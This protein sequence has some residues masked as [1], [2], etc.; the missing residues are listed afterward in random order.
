ML[1]P[2]VIPCLLIKDNYLVKTVNFSNEK[3]IGDPLNAVKIFNEKQVDE[4]MIID[5]SA[6]SSK[7][8]PNFD[9]IAK[10]ANESRMPL[11]YG[12]GVKSLG[13]AKKIIGLGVEKICVSSA[14]VDRRSLCHEISSS[15][16]AQGLVAFIDAKKNFLGKYQ[17]VTNR[18]QTK[19]NIELLGLIEIFQKNGIGELVINC[20][21]KDG[22][23]NGYDIGFIKKIDSK[24]KVPLTILGGAGSLNHIKELVSTFGII[25]CGAGSLFVFKGKY[26]A[27]LINYPNFEEKKPYINLK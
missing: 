10:L 1:R 11:S 20:V 19:H 4:L 13:D 7:K 25:G 5:I 2:R 21:D 16:G 23:M 14:I 9:L 3:Y 12:G 8:D 15:I 26:K 18:A 27:V 6:T 17:V 22:L 24:V